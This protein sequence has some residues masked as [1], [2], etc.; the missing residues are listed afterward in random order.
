M[1]VANDNCPRDCS[2]KSARERMDINAAYREVG[3]YRGAADIYIS[4]PE[5]LGPALEGENTEPRY[6]LGV[7]EPT[8]RNEWLRPSDE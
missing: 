6:N 4:R 5:T 1:W 8:R 7:G 2:M 3:S